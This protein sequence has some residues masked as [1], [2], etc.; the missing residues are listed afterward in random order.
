M[1][2]I[3]SLRKLRYFGSSWVKWINGPEG[4]HEKAT[5]ECTSSYDTILRGNKGKKAM[6]HTFLATSRQP[7]DIPY[8]LS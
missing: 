4:S 3:Y 1:R 6:V 7:I 8:N 5:R 2:D